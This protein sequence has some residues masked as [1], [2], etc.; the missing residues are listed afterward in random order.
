M[1]V[2][3]TGGAHSTSSYGIVSGRQLVYGELCQVK[4][5]YLVSSNMES[6]DFS[7]TSI[8]M[9]CYIGPHSIRRT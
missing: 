3:T 4:Y 6:A 9:S 5:L 2:S 1:E 8:H 7:E